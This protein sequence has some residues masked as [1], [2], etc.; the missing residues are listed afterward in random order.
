VEHIH[1]KRHERSCFH[2]R[3]KFAL[4]E[5]ERGWDVFCSNSNLNF[6]TFH[7]HSQLHPTHLRIAH[8]N[9]YFSAHGTT[10]VT[11]AARVRKLVTQPNLLTNVQIKCHRLLLSINYCK[12]NSYNHHL[13]INT[14]QTGMKK[15]CC[16]YI[17]HKIAVVFQC[18]LILL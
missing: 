3:D 13:K 9:Y 2:D 18:F 10:M 6:S 15:Q 14:V 12:Y 5:K 7:S 17:R 16:S 1:Y 11:A 8:Y 4:Q